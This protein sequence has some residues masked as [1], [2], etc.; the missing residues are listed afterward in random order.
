MNICFKLTILFQSLTRLES[1]CKKHT[2]LV[3]QAMPDLTLTKKQQ[4]YQTNFYKRTQNYT[5]P[6]FTSS[7][8][9]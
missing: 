7:E 6:Q 2:S 3:R 8:D 5:V 1:F 4:T 9:R